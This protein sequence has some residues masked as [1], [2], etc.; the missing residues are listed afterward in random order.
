MK[1]E[2]KTQYVYAVWASDF[3]LNENET[4]GFIMDS[5]LGN[6]VGR[7]SKALIEISWKWVVLL[8]KRQNI[9]YTQRSSV[10][11]MNCLDLD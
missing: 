11:F 6:S 7:Q 1:N 10:G 8:I 9:T 2:T 5:L 4:I 3:R